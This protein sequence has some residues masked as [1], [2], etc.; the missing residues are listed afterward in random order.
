MKLRVLLF[1]VLAVTILCSSWTAAKD[2]EI[3]TP[4]L[5]KT[6]P[7]TPDDL[8]EIALRHS[9][10][11]Q[12]T[13]Y[14]AS[15]N[16]VGVRSAW[17]TLLPSLDVGFSISQSSFFTQT[18]IEAD[19]TVS[20]Y[21]RRELI[22]APVQF[23]D[24]STGYSWIGWDPSADS[25]EFVYD[26]AE[27]KTRSSNAWVSLQETINLGGQQYFGIRNAN[28][29]SRINDLSVSASEMGLL[30]SIRSQYYAVL[31]NQRLLELAIEVLEQKKE[32][33]RLAKARYEVGSVTELDVLQAEIDV[34]NQENAIIS[35]E[36][37]L[38]IAQEEL[39][40]VLGVALDSEFELVDNFSIFEPTYS[41]NEL[42]QSAI[43][44]RPDYQQYL[45]SERMQAN[46]VHIYRGQ[47]FPNLSASLRHSRSENSG[48]NVDFT[49]EPRNRNT[50]LSLSLTWNIFSGFSDEEQYQ[51]A[52]VNLK[53][54]KHDLKSQEQLLEQDVRE[55]YYNLLE[56]H[57]QSRVTEKNQELASR[58][59][60]L[61]Q[62]R[63]R[64]GATSQLNLRT[65]QVTYEQA[66]ADYISNVFT[67][68]SNLASLEYSIG[69]RLQ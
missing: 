10:D 40:R 13:V 47:F 65:A 16:G 35:A 67:F 63:Y 32:Q 66:K 68:W 20:E 28:I 21:P 18:Y 45:E 46:N 26:A 34:G 62:E 51:Q 54:A 19:G 22:P 3:E 59:L 6:G 53:K 50:T 55:A 52:R 48:A 41:L 42:V 7:L 11:H 49:T 43:I 29:S 61:E 33:H 36:N 64:L 5:T 4:R 60:A 8:F 58:Q 44:G 15:L 24:D 69:K 1:A 38:K 23:I 2:D 30:F 12:K 14:D 37:D 17:G 31:S 56:T 27:E 39:N 57:K 25:L 9:P